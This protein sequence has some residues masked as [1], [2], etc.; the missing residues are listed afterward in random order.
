MA[1]TI[2]TQGCANIA[3][4]YTEL[5]ANPQWIPS[6]AHVEALRNQVRGAGLAMDELCKQIDGTVR[7]AADALAR[8][9]E[10]E[11][12]AALGAAFRAQLHECAIDSLKAAT[13]EQ[14]N[15]ILDA[16]RSVIEHDPATA[17]SPK[18]DTR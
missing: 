14:R 16:M 18:D 12:D 7:V 3:E 1:E 2:T 8:L 17:Q 15:Q 9:K 10:H 6:R 4:R 5:L 11:H 13:P